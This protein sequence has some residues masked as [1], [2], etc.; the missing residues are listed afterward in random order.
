MRKCRNPYNDASQFLTFLTILYHNIR[1][2][3]LICSDRQMIAAKGVFVSNTTPFPEAL[4]DHIKTGTEV[5]SGQISDIY[6]A[7]HLK[8]PI[9]GIFP[10]NT[11]KHLALIVLSK[12]SLTETES[13]CARMVATAINHV[14]LKGV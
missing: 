8:E 2:P 11:E 13:V 3:V 12:A 6:L 5:T 1:H 10:V 4:T 14:L 7:P 9:A